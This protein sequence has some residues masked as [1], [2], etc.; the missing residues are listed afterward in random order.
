[1]KT[2]CLHGLNKRIVDYILE[3]PKDSLVFFD[4]GLASLY[5]FKNF[6]L[7]YK[8]VKFIIGINPW[9][10]LQADDCSTKREI[11]TEYIFCTEAH[12]N[13]KNNKFFNY[14]N[15]KM[16]KELWNKGNGCE[17]ADHSWNHFIFE[18]RTKGL[19][20]KSNYYKELVQKSKAFY[21]QLNIYPTKYIRPY[22][23]ENLVYET[24]V[25]KILNV[26]NIYGE[27]RIS[28]LWNSYDKG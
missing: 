2:Y 12:N 25:K 21:D 3:F 11:D 1:M 4:D 26:K 14:L 22:N 19:R 23:K 6:L 15:S 8:E 17:I 28:G 18:K 27:E 7:N 9:V 13:I 20:E 5:Q 10:V 24:Y 16:I